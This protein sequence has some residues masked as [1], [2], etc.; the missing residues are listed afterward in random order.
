MQPTAKKMKIAPPAYTEGRA[1]SNAVEGKLAL[2]RPSR[3]K[4]LTSQSGVPLQDLFTALQT[5]EER[6][7]GID[8]ILELSKA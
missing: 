3:R 8:E 5:E 4:K 7:V 6:P 2:A 1:A